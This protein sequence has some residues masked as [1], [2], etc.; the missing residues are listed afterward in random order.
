[1]GNSFVT[2]NENEEEE[3]TLQS[4]P[5]FPTAKLAEP[6]Q[7]FT[8]SMGDVAVLMFNFNRSNTIKLPNEITQLVFDLAQYYPTTKVVRGG[9]VRI[10]GENQNSVELHHKMPPPVCPFFPMRITIKVQSRDQGWSSY[11]AEHG[12]REGSWTWGEIALLPEQPKEKRHLIYT[13]IHAGIHF[14]SQEIT[15]EHDSELLKVN[16]FVHFNSTSFPPFYGLLLLFSLNSN[17]NNNNNRR[18]ALSC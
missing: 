14:E 9:S 7:N 13:N 15:L 4:Q 16:T 8:P 2:E 10:G 18:F 6:N 5:P 1:M 12:T 11:P 17:N 3:N